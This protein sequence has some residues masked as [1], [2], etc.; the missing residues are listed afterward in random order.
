[1]SCRLICA[2]T[3][4]AL[5]FCGSEVRAGEK[6]DSFHWVNRPGESIDLLFGDRPVLR[7]MNAA[8]DTSTK[9]RHELTFKV[10]HHVLDPK[11]GHILLTGGAGLAADKTLLYPH[12]RGL[13][14]GYNKITHDGQQGD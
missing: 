14:F 1:M 3:I 4:L 5:G 7:Y 11:T 2:V 9:D 8:H 6:Q 12:H 13:F 10:F